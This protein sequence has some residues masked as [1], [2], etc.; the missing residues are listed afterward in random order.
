M[1]AYRGTILCAA[2]GT[3]SAGASRLSMAE[4]RITF[5]SG[6]SAVVRG[7]LETVL[8]ELHK[9]STWREQTFAMLESTDGAPIALR[10]DAVIHVRPLSAGDGP[11]EAESTG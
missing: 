11:P 5:S 7:D 4:C 10:P 2:S 1:P 6:Q 9:A 8:D 3:R